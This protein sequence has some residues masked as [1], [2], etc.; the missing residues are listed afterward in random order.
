MWS[1][2]DDWNRDTYCTDRLVKIYVKTKGLQR[3]YLDEEEGG[4]VIWTEFISRQRLL[5]L[6]NHHGFGSW[7]FSKSFI[8]LSLYF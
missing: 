3:M 2:N 6:I 4:K 8:S 5:Q 1:Q 7:L